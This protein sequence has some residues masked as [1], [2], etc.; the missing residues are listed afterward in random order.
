MVI[1]TLQGLS[2]ERRNQKT[3]MLDTLSIHEIL[4]IMNEEDK[5]VSIAVQETLSS[6]E[7]AIE[8]VVAQLK[9]GGRLIYMGA[10]TSG[11]IAIMDAVE[12]VPTFS[13]KDEVMAIMAGGAKAFISAVEGAE[14]S[15]L[16]AKQDLEAI[17]I[18]S[19]DV[20]MGIAASGRTPYVKGALTYAKEIGAKTISLA[21][22]K[23]AEISSLS[24]VAIEVDAGSEVISG[25]TRLKAGTAQKMIL[26]MISSVSMIQLGKVYGN[27]MVDMKPTNEKLQERAKKIVM[28]ACGCNYDQASEVLKEAGD[29]KVAIVMMLTSCSKEE[30]IHRLQK[31]DGFVRKSLEE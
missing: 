7:Q 18:S 30:A 6:I 13:T 17:S 22:N 16:L 21:C 8:V 12:C 1:E 23:Q 4:C 28:E 27:L 15:E 25:S 26:N 5:E 29:I 3:M 31:S 20:V 11:R 24:D 9:Q 19:K 10:G 14:D 2:T